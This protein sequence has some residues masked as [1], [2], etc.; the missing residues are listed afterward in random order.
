M[1]RVT[2]FNLRTGTEPDG[3]NHWELRKPLV[4][5]VVRAIDP[6]IL[7]AQEALAGQCD[8]LESQLAGAYKRVGV[9]R[10][11][12][13]R[14]EANPILIRRQRFDTLDA[15]TFWLSE[16]PDQPGRKGW[17]ADYPRICTWA[18]VHDRAA[19][20]GSGAAEILLLNT[21]L[22]YAGVVARHES[23]RLIRRFIAARA[24]PIPFILSGD[25]NAGPESETHRTFLSPGDGGPPM[26]DAYR[27]IHPTPSPDEATWHA[28][29][30]ARHGAPIDWILCSPDFRVVTCVI[31]RT[32]RDGRYPSDHFP[33]TAELELR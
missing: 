18:I 32:N 26:I 31:D 16:T 30:G 3:P 19:G 8:F 28:F 27:T 20:A 13:G 22:E 4:L 6:D 12:G 11:D 9:G 10:D 1:L 25:F 2:T 15:G 14:G 29:T 23:A 21:H 24:S 7:G 33:V 5:E 17:D